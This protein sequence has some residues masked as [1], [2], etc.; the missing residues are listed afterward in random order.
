MRNKYPG[1]CYRCGKNVEVGMGHFERVPRGG[2]RVQHAECA[3]EF[4]GQ[5]DDVT[6]ERNLLYGSRR[7]KCDEEIAKG[8]GKGAQRARRRLRE[9]AIKNGDAP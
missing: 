3:I 1:I 7:N 4:R 9:K 5:S 2:W 8:T 6:K